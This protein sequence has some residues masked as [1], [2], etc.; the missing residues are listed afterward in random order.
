[1]SL[2]ETAGH[3]AV[4]KLRKQALDAEKSAHQAVVKAL[5]HLDYTT[6]TQALALAAQCRGSIL[7]YD[8]LIVEYTRTDEPT[9]LN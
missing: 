4:L 1:M 8:K 9:E 7:V 5:A 3:T 2:K 6:A